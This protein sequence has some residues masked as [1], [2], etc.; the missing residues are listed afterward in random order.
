MREVIEYGWTALGLAVFGAWIIATVITQFKGGVP[1]LIGRYD[2]FHL[3]PKWTFF[4]PTP[5]MLDYHLVARD[6]DVE[7]NP[8]T[9]WCEIP[10]PNRSLF[11]PLWNPEKR[12]R[13]VL[14]DYVR[15]LMLA[16]RKVGADGLVLS[17]PYIACL[18]FTLSR[19][20]PVPTAKA[21][22]FGLASTRG[23]AAD[24]LAIVFRSGP[25]PLE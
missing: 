1:S 7:G 9:E 2:W 20:R 22:Q 19:L 4:A 8:C 3:I 12:Q 11:G 16:H 25:H 17:I 6:L 15:G 13:K 23:E 14:T 24:S 21:R 18:Q 10:L 5:G